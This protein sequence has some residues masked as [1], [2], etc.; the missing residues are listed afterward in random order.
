MPASISHLGDSKLIRVLRDLT[1]VEM[2]RLEKFIHSPFFCTDAK[3]IELFDYLKELH[4]EFPAESLGKTYLSS[5]FFPEENG[6]R[7][8]FRKLRLCTTYLLNRVYDFFKYEEGQRDPVLQQFYLLQNLHGRGMV[9]DQDRLL[10]KGFE[11]ASRANARSEMDHLSMYLFSDFEMVKASGRFDSHKIDQTINYLDQFYLTAK[12]KR[13]CIA[14]QLRRLNREEF[15]LNT[16]EETLIYCENYKF[17]TAFT[18]IYF[19]LL[20][21]FIS[22]EAHKFS[23]TIVNYRLAKRLRKNYLIGFDKHSL[24]ET[25]IGVD[26]I[27]VFNQ[28]ISISNALYRQGFSVYQRELF[29]LYKEMLTY[30]MLHYGGRI[31]PHH[32]KN[33]VT[34]GLR[35][36]ELSWIDT[37]I[38]QYKDHLPLE[39]K[40]DV[41]SYNLAHLQLFR[42]DFH[43][44]HRILNFTQF[45]D[46]FYNVDARVMSLK[47]FYGKYRMNP[48][49]LF[50]IDEDYWRISKNFERYLRREPALSIFQK[51]LYQNFIRYANTLWRI[52]IGE[53]NI[54]KDLRYEIDNCEFL[55]EKKWLLEQLGE[56]V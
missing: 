17:R 11:I 13:F 56:M 43:A 36:G 50:E 7:N 35:L 20:K 16:L 4:P 9:E 18:A 23:E 37:F 15:T 21:A 48:K 42:E 49:D 52:L 33:M 53:K 24:I 12:L 47:A 1:P 28:S 41:Y 6:K 46:P 3:T 10:K 27:T 5:V 39:Q 2:N 34:L 14:L 8:Y 32:Y 40:K 45:I 51:K 30:G 29:S 25:Q 55:H 22:L 26:A 31:F 19:Y 54:S 44:V 38:H